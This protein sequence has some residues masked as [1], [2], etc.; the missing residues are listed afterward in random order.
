MIR[1][2][3]LT[4]QIQR[5]TAT[6]TGRVEALMGTVRVVVHPVPDAR[7]GSSTTNTAVLRHLAKKNPELT[8]P[9]GADLDALVRSQARAIWHPK[10]TGLEELA[11]AIGHFVSKGV[12]ERLRSGRF[13]TN[14]AETA[15]RKGGRPG[16][17]D[18]G[19]LADALDAATV[20]SEGRE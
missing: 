3:T 12:A 19:Q 10:R 6:L 13:V 17:I 4:A 18:T 16:G 14:D 15:R 1:V 7:E 2:G 8:D 11:V 9:K 5:F 20:T